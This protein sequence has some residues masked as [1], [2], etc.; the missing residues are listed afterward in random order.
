MSRAI[1]YTWGLGLVLAAASP[2]LR[3]PLADDFPLSTFPMF[4]EPLEQAEFY[5][6]E[7]VRHDRSRVALRPELVANGAAMQTVQTMRDA[8]ARGAHALRELCERI[9]SRAA[10]DSALRDIERVELVNA[11]YDPVAYFTSSPEP[12]ARQV[13]RK[14]R[15]PSGP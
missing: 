8:H 10:H 5:S 6:A 7:G 9:A 3:N 11:R 15:V 1:A 4:A 2:L 12:V 13:L 14:C